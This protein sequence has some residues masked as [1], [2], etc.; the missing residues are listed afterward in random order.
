MSM[1]FGGGFL[2]VLQL[3]IFML[4]RILDD[5]SWYDFGVVN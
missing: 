1:T 4:G 3:A 2:L 5:M